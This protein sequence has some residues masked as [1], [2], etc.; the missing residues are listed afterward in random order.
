[1]LPSAKILA[2]VPLVLTALCDTAQADPFGLITFN[3]YRMEN[4]ATVVFPGNREHTS[5]YPMSKRAASVW[6]SDFCW[7]DC[8][9]QSGWKFQ[10]CA[11]AHGPELCRFQL[12]T[13]NRACLRACRLRGGPMVNLAN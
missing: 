7:N 2:A 9:G 13:D 12:D 3:S 5:P 11:R 10:A 4:R 6:V 1:M 8:T